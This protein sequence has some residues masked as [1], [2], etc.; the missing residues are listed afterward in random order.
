MQAVSLVCVLA[1]L[2]L[3]FGEVHPVPT[4]SLDVAPLLAKHCTRCHRQNQSG[5][6]P[7]DTYEQA[8]GY[9]SE[10]RR[11]VAARKM[12]P[13]L[14]VPGFGEFSNE[15]TLTIAE[16]QMLGRWADA[17]APRGNPPVSG[18]PSSLSDASPGPSDVVIE[19]EASYKVPSKGE[20]EVRC[21]AIP[22]N[23]KEAKA[24]RMINVFP[25]DSRVVHYARIFVDN[26]GRGRRLDEADP[27]PGFDC[28]GE[29]HN[30]S[31]R[32]S[33]GEWSAGSP[34]D[35]LPAGLGRMLPANTGVVLEIQ[36]NSLGYPVS[37]RSRAGLYFA[38]SPVTP[39]QSRE[40][41]N[42]EL[43]VPAGAWDYQAAASWVTNNIDLLSVSPHMHECGTEM[44]VTALLPD[45][46][47]KNILWV[48]RFEWARQMAYV[49]KT[50]L[51][52]PKGTRLQAVAHFDN[53]SSNLHRR[54][55]GP[56][57]AHWGPLRGQEML[58]LFVE[59]L[60]RPHHTER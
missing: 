57:T 30:M 4:Y 13:W 35:E 12:P 60:D 10:I 37:D 8:R 39:V 3:A 6:I 31:E 53:S 14:G 34:P 21:F 50:P 20:A 45:G 33:L 27:E 7:L 5:R 44:R 56:K 22:I 16:I 29:S 2:G 19:M 15:T 47:T 25:G 41:S 48:R 38:H 28:F 24:V 36:Y 9:A 58:T 55:A 43:T 54:E 52:L 23:L 17:G 42:R 32:Q 59:Y 11:A 49:L 18:S 40:I 1:G 51:H 26:D 46:T